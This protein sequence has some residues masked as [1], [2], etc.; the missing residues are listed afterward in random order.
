M[1]KSKMGKK[2]KGGGVDGWVTINGARVPITGGQLGG[3]VGKKVAR[4][5]KGKKTAKSKSGATASSGASKAKK[6]S[7]NSA[8]AA[9]KKV[10]KKAPA[11]EQSKAAAKKFR[12]NVTAQRKAEQAAEVKKHGAKTVARER[13][14]LE[15]GRNPEKGSNKKSSAS[16]ATKAHYESLVAKGMSKDKARAQAAAKYAELQGGGRKSGQKAFKEYTTRQQWHGKAKEKRAAGDDRGAAATSRVSVRPFMRKERDRWRSKK[17]NESSHHGALVHGPAH[18]VGGSNPI[19]GIVHSNEPRTNL[20]Q[21][22]SGNPTT[23]GRRTGPGP[24]AHVR[25]LMPGGVRVGGGRTMGTLAR[26]GGKK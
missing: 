16:K 17:G 13:K 5:S 20:V 1:A 26:Y 18:R 23:A 19:A 10:G 14:S 11:K 12:K 15:K 9:A 25:S 24:E 22:L 2:G 7:K 21:D 6:S 4:T 8:A 3:K